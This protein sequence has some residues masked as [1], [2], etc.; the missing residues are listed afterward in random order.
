[1]ALQG[2]ALWVSAT[3]TAVPSAALHMLI[4]KAPEGLVLHTHK[5]HPAALGI[6]TGMQVVCEAQRGMVGFI[7]VAVLLIKAQVYKLVVGILSFK[8][9][10]V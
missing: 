1:M 7:T 5:A 3:C 2:T 6:N 9:C 4:I 10:S 8:G